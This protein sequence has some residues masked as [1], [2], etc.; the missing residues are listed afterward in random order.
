MKLACLFVCLMSAAAQDAELKRQIDAETRTMY[1]KA[2]SRVFRLASACPPEWKLCEVTAF[3]AGDSLARVVVAGWE[4]RGRWA[5][6]YYLRGDA[7]IFIYESL[8]YLPE[9]APIG[10]WRNFKGLP[11][12]ERR[13][14]FRD[15]KAGHVETQGTG[16]FPANDVTVRQLRVLLAR[17]R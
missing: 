16:E 7:I 17:E 2:Q 5:A 14:Y 8:E 6:E 15:G 12:W 11:A 10:A 3:Y 4:D 9:K 13:T 1:D